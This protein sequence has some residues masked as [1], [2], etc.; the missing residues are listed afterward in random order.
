VG[1]RRLKRKDQFKSLTSERDLSNII[2]ID[3]YHIIITVVCFTRMDLR[4][5]VF[6]P[7]A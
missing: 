1:S 6:E 7:Y 4:G 2:V 3:C 5:E